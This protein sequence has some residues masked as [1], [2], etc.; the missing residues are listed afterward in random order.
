MLQKM[1]T[2]E[3][4]RV[5]NFTIEN[6]YGKV[7]Y[8]DPTDLTEVDLGD[9]VTI[10]N[11]NAEVYDDKRIATKKPPVG[12]KLNKRAMITLYNIKP[13]QGET[14]EEK[15]QRLKESFDPKEVR[16]YSGN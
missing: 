2:D 16:Y 10:T 3:L 5:H 13:R 14:A 11:R 12:E 7:H 8:P 6:Q 9:I 15:V 4:R 1:T